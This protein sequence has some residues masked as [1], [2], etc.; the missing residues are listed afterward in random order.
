MY[1]ISKANQQVRVYRIAQTFSFKENKTIHTE[2]S[3]KYTLEQ[4]Q[5]LTLDCGFQ[6]KI[7]NWH[8][9]HAARVPAET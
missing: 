7:Y 4:I 2:N 6:P 8:I 1:L 5:D 3:H 9:F